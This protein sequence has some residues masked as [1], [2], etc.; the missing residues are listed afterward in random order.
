[1]KKHCAALIMMLVF[2]VVSLGA[3]EFWNKKQPAEWSADELNT[4]LTKSPWAK[5]AKVS[6]EGGGPGG[7][8]SGGGGYPGGRGG[9]GRSGGGMGRPG[10]G[11]YPGG[12]GYPGGMGRRSP[13]M[14][15]PSGGQGGGVGQGEGGEGRSRGNF[16]PPHIVVRWESALPVKQAPER[17][18]TGDSC[19]GKATEARVMNVG[20]VFR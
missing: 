4:L 11:G 10:G 7:G 18:D 6:F 19:S 20:E 9:S 14:G 17:S 2:C 13:G 16:A 15:T 8:R 5:E 12:S 3:E 1:M